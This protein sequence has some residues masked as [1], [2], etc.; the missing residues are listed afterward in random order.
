MMAMSP[1]G[2]GPVSVGAAGGMRWYLPIRTRLAK[3][4]AGIAEVDRL[5]NELEQNLESARLSLKRGF[6]PDPMMPSG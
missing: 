5:L 1:Q 6:I 3:S 2:S 4:A